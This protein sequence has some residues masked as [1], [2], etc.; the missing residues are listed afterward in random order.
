MTHRQR[1][2]APPGSE[3]MKNLPPSQAWGYIRAGVLNPSSILVPSIRHHPPSSDT[4][5]TLLVGTASRMGDALTVNRIEFKC[6]LSR[7]VSNEVWLFGMLRLFFR[8]NRSA[9]LCWRLAFCWT[10]D[11]TV[12]SSLGQFGLSKSWTDRRRR[13]TRIGAKPIV[14]SANSDDLETKKTLSK[15]WHCCAITN[16]ALIS[17]IMVRLKLWQIE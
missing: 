8:L 12:S 17:E 11:A 7:L 4:H 10:F 16:R 5:D 13:M 6:D 1:T 15:C 2:T 3:W 14:S 9:F